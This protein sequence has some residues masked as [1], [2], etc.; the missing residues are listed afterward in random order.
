MEEG[1]GAGRLLL[2]TR[3]LRW[4]GIDDAYTKENFFRKAMLF[5]FSVDYFMTHW[6]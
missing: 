4:N 3:Y 5:F 6:H 2:F 1:E